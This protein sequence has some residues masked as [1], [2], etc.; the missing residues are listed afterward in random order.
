VHP[1]PTYAV[2]DA[3]TDAVAN[4]LADASFGRQLHHCSRY[5]AVPW[6]YKP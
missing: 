3:F 1:A 4:S 5:E 2:S 6:T